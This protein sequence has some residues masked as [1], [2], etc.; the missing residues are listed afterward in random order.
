MA[1]LE[2]TSIICPDQTFTQNLLSDGVDI[3]RNKT[4]ICS[5]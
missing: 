3:Y 2:S 1:I 5:I 4:S